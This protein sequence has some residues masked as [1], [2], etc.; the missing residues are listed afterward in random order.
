M[1]EVSLVGYWTIFF[2]LVTDHSQ[3]WGWKV[4]SLKTNLYQICKEIYFLYLRNVYFFHLLQDVKNLN[5]LKFAAHNNISQSHNHINTF[6]RIKISK[7][8]MFHAS[9]FWSRC[10]LI[11]LHCNYSCSHLLCPERGTIHF[12][13]AEKEKEE[14]KPFLVWCSIKVLTT[15]L[16]CTSDDFWVCKFSEKLQF[17][18]VI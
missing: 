6:L 12:M 11:I 16:F 13:L 17:N 15:A 18:F 7:I 5:W 10:N 3:A 4:I 2:H 8:F 9:T 14:E 1:T